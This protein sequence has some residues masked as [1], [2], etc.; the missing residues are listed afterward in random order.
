MAPR[1][2]TEC[3]HCRAPGFGHINVERGA[4]C[5]FYGSAT[6][7]IAGDIH[8]CGRCSYQTRTPR[9]HARTDPKWCDYCNS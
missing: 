9:N 2:A 7:T 5:S 1:L 3:P 8:G 4:P 6:Q